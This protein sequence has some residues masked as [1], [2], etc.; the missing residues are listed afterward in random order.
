MFEYHVIHPLKEHIQY[1][2]LAIVK[3][4]L[5]NTMKHSNA[6]HYC[7]QLLEQPGFYQLIIKDDGTIY[8]ESITGIGLPS[9][10][11]R[12]DE[13]NGF[14][15]ITHTDGFQIFITLQKEGSCDAHCDY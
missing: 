5:N 7:V 2:I 10:H 6:S 9:I 14:M 3:E 1:H 15:N 11:Q 4:S 13:I 8:N 12:I